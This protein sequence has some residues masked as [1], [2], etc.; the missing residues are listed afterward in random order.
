[1]Q[2]A[3]AGAVLAPDEHAHLF[4][5]VRQAAKELKQLGAR[6]VVLFGSLAQAGG[7]TLESDVD[8][9][10]L[11]LPAERYWAAWQVAEEIVGDRL[12]D[13]VALEQA[14]EPLRRAIERNGVEL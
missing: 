10:V 4:K 2:A 5:R 11:D 7:A 12:V 14:S 3:T 9:A 8:L 13:L 6:R 1:M